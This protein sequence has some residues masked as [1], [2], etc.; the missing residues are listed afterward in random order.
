MTAAEA[1]PS[2]LAPPRATAG[3]RAA[4]RGAVILGFVAVVILMTVSPALL[5]ALGVPYMA[6][7]GSQA[8]KIHPATWAT[9]LAMLPLIASRGGVVR[10]MAGEAI[11]RPGVA[12]FALATVLLFFHVVTVSSL[13]VSPVID[14]FLLP[15]LLV[16]VVGA[17]TEAERGRLVVFLHLLFVINAL[18]GCVEYASSWRLTP[19]FD[20]DGRILAQDW[21][22]SAIFGHPLV[23]A[24]LDGTWLLALACGATP[25]LPVVLRLGLM[26]LATVAMV[27]FGGRVAMVF[28]VVILGA[29]GATRGVGVLLGGRFRLD[30]AAAA[31]AVATVAALFVVVFV[32]MGGA[33][34]FLERFS[35]DHGSAQARVAMF[36]IFGDLTPEQF[37]LWS[38]DRLI[39]QAQR[40]YGIRVGVESTEVAFVAFYG[41][42]VTLVF[43]AGLGLFLH[44][45][46]RATGPRT[47]WLVLYFVVVMSGSNGIAA[48]SLSLA[49]LVVMVLVLMPRR[50]AGGRRLS[51]PWAPE[52]GQTGTTVA[53]S[54][55]SDGRPDAGAPPPRQG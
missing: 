1:N 38:D 52:S 49:Q 18:I 47:G 7:G 24:F 4:R 46:M 44:E 31:I 12:A 41:L 27:A 19:M 34:R 14:T 16:S 40:E 43:L 54:P 48:K 25:R 20:A 35:S 11:D 39:A 8:L 6:P 9:A 17:M 50:G 42:A 21:R 53:G 22:A 3:R 10:F 32:D 23:N 13:P 45:L 33:D 28:A 26:A 37:V 51:S 5:I 55:P 2:Y 30:A 36:K 15:I 29:I